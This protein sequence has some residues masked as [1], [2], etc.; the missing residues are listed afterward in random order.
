VNRTVLL[1]TLAAWLAVPRS[2]AAQNGTGPIILRLPG[3]VRASTLGNAFVAGSGPG[4]LFYNPAQ[5]SQG[6]GL[7]LFLARYGSASTHAGLAS[8]LPFG[9]VTLGVGVQYLDYG[10]A[11]PRYSPTDVG[12]LPSRHPI[13][14][15]S[16]SAELA[17]GIRWQG[18]RWGGAI[19]YAQ[20]QIDRRTDRVAGDF[21]MAREFGRV[22]LG[23]AAQDLAWRVGPSYETLPTRLTLGAMLARRPIGTYFDIAAAVAVTRQRG[24]R[25]VPGGGL[26]LYYQPLEGWSFVVRAGARRAEESQF[27]RSVRPFTFGAGFGLDRFALDYGFE[28]IREAGPVHRFGIRIQ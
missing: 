16:L 8:T 21:G 24:G 9:V 14:A 3:G 12:D 28:S 5:I 18:F 13:D 2:L 11:D 23:L 26:E 19:K 22:T 15:F 20:K 1:L 6:T 17:G 27:S 4:V 25:L 10:A 7:E